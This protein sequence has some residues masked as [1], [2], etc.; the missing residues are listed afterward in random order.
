MS[1]P[2][3]FPPPIPVPVRRRANLPAGAVAAALAGCT[4]IALVWFV[5]A[6]VLI[7]GPFHEWSGMVWLNVVAGLVSAFVLVVPVAFLLARRVW[8][9]WTLFGLC[10]LYVVAVVVVP[11]PPGTSFGAH[12]DFVLGFHKSNGVPIGLATIFA[13]LTAIAAV[14]SATVRPPRR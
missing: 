13:F 3:G 1:V 5:L 6:N 7:G 2:Q 8:A 12:L 14:V 9:A 11:M 10:L 4:A